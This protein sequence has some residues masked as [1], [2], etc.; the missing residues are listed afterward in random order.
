MYY[1]PDQEKVP[2]GLFSQGK[3]SDGYSCPAIDVTARTLAANPQ[4]ISARLCLGDFWR[5]NGF[6]DFELS[7]IANKPDELAGVANLFPG[8]PTP[9][10]AI[11][12]SIIA[13]PKAAGPDKAYALYRAVMCYARSGS[14][15]CGGKDVPKSQRKA[16]YDQLKRDY[17]SSPWAKKLRYY[18]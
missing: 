7:G 16:W 2:V 8:K 14:N 12:T 9:R 18:W 6:D 3:W 11:Y 13:D 4:A 17:P 15:G 5:L 1:L 10:S